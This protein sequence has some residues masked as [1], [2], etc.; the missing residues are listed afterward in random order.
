MKAQPTNPI[1]TV[2]TISTGFLIIYVLSEWNWALGVSIG[3]GIIGVFSNYLSRKIDFLWMKLTWI[4][5][6][7]IPNIIL[8]L[9]FYFI[10][11]PFS[12][13]ARI[14]GGKNYLRLKNADASTFNIVDKSFDKKSIENPW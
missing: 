4:L 13:F 12:V 7:I 9:I 11:F 3:T 14:F 6:L 8:G 1:R 10:L 5:S 2:I